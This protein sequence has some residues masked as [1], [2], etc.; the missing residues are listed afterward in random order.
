[1]GN[2]MKN[3]TD[4]AAD[5]I[6][7]SQIRDRTKTEVTA[8]ELYSAE[9][10]DNVDAVIKS[11]RLN[12]V[13][14]KRTVRANGTVREQQDFEF[15]PSMAEQHTAHLTNINYLIEKYKP[16]ELAAYIAAR[17]VHR[18]E[19]IGHDFSKEPDLQEAKNAVYRSRQEF[20][21]LDPEVRSQFPNH[22]E[23][24]KFVDNP[25]NAEKLIK[26]GLATKKQINV[27]TSPITEGQE[28]TPPTPTTQE[29]K[30]K[31]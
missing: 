16:D 31:K 12:Q 18:Q 7:Q 28:T 6:K 5:P 30:E 26:L 13:I 22:L 8:G 1:M 17:S 23:F 24:L 14:I 3:K 10:R 27:I 9:Y 20:E 29:E 4:I 15:C 19:I 21:N 25:A 11:G 2:A